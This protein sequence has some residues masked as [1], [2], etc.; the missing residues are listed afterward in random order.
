MRKRS[1]GILIK[2]KEGKYRG[3]ILYILSVYNNVNK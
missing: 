3:L 2:E 1:K